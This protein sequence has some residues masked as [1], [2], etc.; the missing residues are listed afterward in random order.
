[1]DQSKKPIVMFAPMPF[2]AGVLCHSTKV[3]QTTVCWSARQFCICQPQFKVCTIPST[4]DVQTEQTLRT[5][6]LTS[7][8]T[9]D[10]ASTLSCS[11]AV[12]HVCKKLHAS[13]Y[14][15]YCSRTQPSQLPC[16]ALPNFHAVYRQYL[17]CSDHAVYQHRSRCWS[18]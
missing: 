2:C 17:R 9:P 11:H 1:M 18:R 16:S 14:L 5:Y 6:E 7:C 3:A 12:A 8:G 13:E 10:M 4:S 15:E